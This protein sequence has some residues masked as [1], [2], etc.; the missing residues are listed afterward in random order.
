MESQR[1]PGAGGL[2]G[3]RPGAIGRLIAG[4]CLLALVASMADVAHAT[5]S[6]SCRIPDVFLNLPSDL[7][8]TER[9][10][11]LARPVRIYVIGPSI[12][13]SPLSEKRRG[14][15]T[16]ELERRL[17]DVKFEIVDDGQASGFA[18]DDFSRIRNEVARAE[19]D[20]VLWQ[21]GTTD[22]LAAVDTDRFGETLLQAAEWMKGRGIDFILIDPPFVPQVQ[23][24]ELYWRIV[25]KISE[26]SD[27]AN[28]NLFRRYAAM[29]YLAV[30]QQ[31]LPS[32][33]PDAA[34]RRV[35][36]SELVAEAIVKAV[37]R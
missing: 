1:S 2:P 24:E 23:H 3:R 7:K 36:M 34:H 12:G 17:P 19:P 26:V 9:L 11:D 30:E 16:T 25:G 15:L 29:Q 37:T 21:V 20:L 6:P 31:K 35:C 8:R 27:K 14:R 33:P 5:V 18:W 28:L 32:L 4:L 13:G 10:V 22:A